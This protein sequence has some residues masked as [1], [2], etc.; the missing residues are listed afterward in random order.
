[1]RRAVQLLR[2]DAAD[3]LEF[4]R[5]DDAQQRR[6]LFQP[7]RVDLVEQERAF[8]DGGELADLGPVRAGEGPLTWPKNSLSTR[9]ADM[10]PQGTVRK[11]CCFARRIL[12]H[13]PGQV[14]LAGAGLA[15]EQHRD[16]VVGG[17]GDAV[18]QRQQRRRQASK[19]RV[20]RTSSSD[21]RFGAV[22]GPA[23]TQVLD[24]LAEQAA[25]AGQRSR[26]AT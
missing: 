16:V 12:V 13:Q 18:H 4:A 22:E 25:S 5:L 10:A 1:M 9:L 2:L 15:G 20:S 11:R 23:M 6:L 21:L 7:E 8:A 26:R 19:R 14:R 17:Q 24:H 3:R